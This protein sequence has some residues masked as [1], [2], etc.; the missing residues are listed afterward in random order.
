MKRN[1]SITIK[2]VAERAG[3]SQ[4]TAARALGDYGR[5]GA[6]T[7]RRVLDAAA[8]MGYH[9]NALARSMVT[10]TTQTL[11]LVLADI[12]NLFFARIARAVADVAHQRGY[13]LVLAN[14]DENLTNEQEAVRVLAEK[15][16][17]G[18]IV[19]PASSTDAAHLTALIDHG[20]PVV[21]MDR[22]IDGLDADTIMVDNVTAAY[23]AIA[24][25]TALG[26]R[27]IAM[28]SASD[29][30]ATTAARM[31]GYRQALADAGATAPDQWGRLAEYSQAAAKAETMALL[32]QPRSER[33]TALFAT[34]SILTAG[35]FQGVQ[36][37]GLAVPVDVSVIGFDDVE[38]MTMVRPAVTVVDQP[39]YEL[40]KRAAEQLMARIEGDRGPARHVLLDTTLIVRDSCAAPRAL[41]G[42]QKAAV[43]HPAT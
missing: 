18:L 20:I 7:R 43:A 31:A 35:A 16:V 33:P 3:V 17:D 6:E 14:S 41:T 39:V 1:G 4:A 11:G 29:T 25:L 13:A 34:D 12:E 38:W 2:D 19:V 36:A 5:I 27:H 37:L 9:A 22:F 23:R 10:G 40:G 30:I 8:A 21:L 32:S 42:V 15:R 24:H 26:H 28:I